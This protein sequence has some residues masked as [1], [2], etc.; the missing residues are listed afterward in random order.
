MV[1]RT[2][3][4]ITTF[5]A[6]KMA[7]S[8]P[9]NWADFTPQQKI[10]FFNQNNVTENLLKSTGVPTNDIEWM[11]SNGYTPPKTAANG[12]LIIDTSKLGDQGD[13]TYYGLTTL[14]GQKIYATTDE[15]GNLIR[16][17]T[18]PTS[19][20]QNSVITQL[21]SKGNSIGTSVYQP[22]TETGFLGAIGN[23]GKGL[24]GL[25]LGVAFPELASTIGTSLGATGAAA[26]AVGGAALGGL[27]SAA[28][29]GNVLQ[30]AALGGLGGY[31]NASGG[32][33]NYINPGVSD[34]I[35]IGGGWNP[36]GNN[37]I[38]GAP[39][40]GGVDYSLTGQPYTTNLTNPNLADMNGGQG[41]TPTTGTN[42][43]DMNGGQGIVDATS[44]NLQTMNGG[45]GITAPAS[46]GGTLGATGVNT[47]GS[48]LGVNPLTGSTLGTTLSGLNTGLET[49]QISTAGGL[50]LTNNLTGDVLGTKLADIQTPVIETGR[51]TGT[52]TSTGTGTNTVTG[53]GT[54]T[55]TGL[56]GLTGL[57]GTTIAGLGSIL[58][59][60]TSNAV[61]NTGITN[62]QNI[63]NAAAAAAQTN[64]KDIYGQQ[65]GFTKPY[66]D[67]GVQGTS[68][69][70][71]NLP[72][73]QHQFDA[74][75]LNTNLAPN[76]A[77]QLGQGQMANQ[78]AANVGGGA[79]SGNTLTGL[80]RYTQDYAGNAYQQ[81]FN[82][83]NTQ[84]NNIYNTL[85][86]IAGL[87]N[88]SNAQA[89][90]AG[91]TYGTNTTNL[92]TGLAAAQAGA[93]VA[94][95]TNNA[96]TLNNIV[97]NAALLLGQNNS[98]GQSNANLATNPYFATV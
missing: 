84:R 64:L 38:T 14:N 25:A 1:S 80:N 18:A 5:K 94:Q 23:I 93:N 58:G 71:S 87:G 53:T 52:G 46:G 27:T 86:N 89:I 63:Q 33:G 44:A 67:L 76:Y 66:Q 8:L 83:Y 16:A 62:A 50:P 31:V 70:S 74:N 34:N 81:A 3:F 75:D 40:T 69:I 42:L 11:K 61:T 51:G 85:S 98:P 54:G 13:G 77:F 7:I 49:N 29:G 9:S 24:G 30:G 28:T 41:L 95:S 20:T 21:D 12:N 35:D 32:V 78:R 88:T 4:L 92:T 56:T 72:Y 43:S 6:K 2:K 82:N 10:D 48:V 68:A 17:A 57:T 26:S 55:G 47:G 59:G 97:N 65:L 45:Q 60:L 79:L 96:N 22:Q 90:G 15:Q 39:L 37:V 19:N 73:F 91:N 36:A